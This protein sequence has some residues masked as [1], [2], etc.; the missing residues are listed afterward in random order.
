MEPK[1]AKNI[2]GFS[3][4]TIIKGNVIVGGHSTGGATAI[5]T[6]ENDNRV[7]AVLTHDPWPQVIEPMIDNFK[8]LTSK[9]I[10]I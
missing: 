10:Q 5:K 4:D 7:K 1:F 8:N 3:A 2:L 9:P 6:G